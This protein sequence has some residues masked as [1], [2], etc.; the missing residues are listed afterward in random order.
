MGYMQE[1]NGLKLWSGAVP[2]MQRVREV[3]SD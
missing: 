1:D 2:W 3:I